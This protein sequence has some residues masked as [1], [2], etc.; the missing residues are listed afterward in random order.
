MIGGNP[1]VSCTALDHG[2][3]GAHHTAHGADFLPVRIC[4]RGHCKKVPEQFI[5]SVDQVHIHIVPGQFPESHVTRSGKRFGRSV[6][7]HGSF[8]IDAAIGSNNFA[9]SSMLASKLRRS[10]PPTSRLRMC[11]TDV[12]FMPLRSLY[13]IFSG[14]ALSPA[15]TPARR[16]PFNL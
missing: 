2:Q 11:T 14:V 8:E 3:N 1:N 7:C 9:G 15:L 6:P 5:C 12:W 16:P 4:C 10:G 13:Q